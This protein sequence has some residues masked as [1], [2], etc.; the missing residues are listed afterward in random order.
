MSETIPELQGLDETAEAVT[1]ETP[2][3]SAAA[4]PRRREQ[5]EFDLDY[6]DTQGVRRTGTFVNSILTIKQKRE[7][8]VLKA[9]LSG[10]TPVSALDADTW[11]LNEMLAH[12]KLSLTKVPAGY[13]N[14]EALYDEGI[15]RAIYREVALH[16]D[17]FHGRPTNQ[18]VGA[19]SGEGAAG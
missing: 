3:K 17:T 2:P 12:L 19:E 7:R 4:D 18:A 5:Y 11:E 16:E 15:V 14:L 8:G 1:G 9:R 6:K 13:E 10:N